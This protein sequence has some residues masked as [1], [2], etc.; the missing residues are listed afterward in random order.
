MPSTRKRRVETSERYDQK[1][2]D[3]LKMS[4][5]VFAEKGFH[6]ASMRDISRETGISLAGLYYYFE[7]K[8]ELLYLILAD[9]FERV[10]VRLDESVQDHSGSDRIRFFI[11]NHLRYFVEN[12]PQMKVASHESDSLSGVYRR[13]IR[14]KKKVYFDRLVDLLSEGRPKKNVDPK[15][16]ALSLFGMV[17]WIY[18]WYDPRKNGSIEEISSTMAEIFL[19]GY[20]TR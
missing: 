6:N 17:N 8:E 13:K 20:G 3:I 19:K 1:L 4:S 18:T 10:I 16:A 9:T 14:A 15:M 12:L 5:R 7:T 2:R 11:E